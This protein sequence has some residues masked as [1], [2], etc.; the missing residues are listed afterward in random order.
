MNGLRE[1]PA[2]QSRDMSVTQR[3][4]THESHDVKRLSKERSTPDWSLPRTV[5]MPHVLEQYEVPTY[6]SCRKVNDSWA[7][8]LFIHV[9]LPRSLSP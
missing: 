2:K 4:L 5:L 1:V 7:R 8:R 3:S 6:F 9:Q